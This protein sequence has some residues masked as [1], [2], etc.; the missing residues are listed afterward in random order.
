MK[1]QILKLMLGTLALTGASYSSDAQALLKDLEPGNNV[2]S[3]PHQLTN[4]D[5]TV[6]FFTDPGLTR[7]HALW[8]TDG[9][10]AGTV[11]VKDSIISTPVA[12]RLM[13]QGVSHDTM[14]YTVNT[15]VQADT[16]TEL[17]IVKNGSAP[18]LVTL[19]TS[20]MV[21]QFSNGEPRK[22]AMAGS[23]LFF[24][25]YTEHGYELWV[26]DGTA[27]GTHEV[28]DLFPGEN[29]GIKNGGTSDVPMLGYNGKIYF[30]G[31]TAYNGVKGLYSSDGNTID[32]VK[33]GD[34]FDPS[35]FTVFNN[36][37]YFYAESAASGTGLWKTNGTNAGT[38]NVTNTG[39]NGDAVIFKG[40][41]YYNV[42]NTTYKLDGTTG[43]SAVFSDSTGAIYGMNNDYFF[44]RRTRFISTAPYVAYDYL[45]SDGSIAG[46]QR[47]DDSVGC[48]ASFVVLNNI[49]YGIGLSDGLWKSDGTT[50]GAK[51]LLEGIVSSPIIVNNRLVFVNF[52]NGTG[53][54]P[55]VYIPAGGPSGIFE[56]QQD[57]SDLT[58]YPNP[59]TGYVQL[60]IDRISVNAVVEVYN[61]SGEKVYHA[62]M[63]KSQSEIDLSGFARGIYFVKIND[64]ANVY[65]RKLSLQ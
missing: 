34:D 22:Y 27:A 58:I 29:S 26:S 13:V 16:T 9:T 2:G 30:Q 36:T 49:M 28:A 10:E 21:N 63:A 51:K 39:F 19:L 46:T 17:W 4:V 5:G 41:M 14:Y 15:N 32:L 24:Q 65:S 38:V 43:N 1:K 44:S 35:S 47:I 48:S 57:N 60:N 64:G 56:S 42:G 23:K 25:M 3:G 8:K 31:L 18:V 37:L 7:R 55:W 6:Y 54:E 40:N 52:G 20:K 50:A 61:T 59:S 53:Y 12:G 11:M 33:E 45:R 62:A